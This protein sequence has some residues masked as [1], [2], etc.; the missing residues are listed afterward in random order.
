MRC[1]R[2][3]PGRS[4]CAQRF[5]LL[6]ISRCLFNVRVYLLT[7]TGLEYMLLDHGAHQVLTGEP[8][9]PVTASGLI[10]NSSGLRLWVCCWAK[11]SR[12]SNR[13]SIV[14]VYCGTFPFDLTGDET[15][16]APWAAVHPHWLVVTRC[17]YLCSRS[18]SL[19]AN[20]GD[21]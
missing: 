20:D 11:W 8:V 12:S 5:R 19:T 17:L 13:D 21:L 9:H 14:C 15:W 6:W 10:F 16:R 18:P 7:P 3:A 2:D 4:R 1:A